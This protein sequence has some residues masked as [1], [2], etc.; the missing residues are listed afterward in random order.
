MNTT[1][2][3][4]Y[5]TDIKFRNAVKKALKGFT[6]LG[7]N[8]VSRRYTV[9]VQTATYKDDITYLITY[10]GG[11]R[12]GNEQPYLQKRSEMENQLAAAGFEMTT[13]TDSFGEPTI[14]WRKAVN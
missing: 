6:V 11:D 7:K 2:A 14:A 8:E 9:R 3:T 1:T 4:E 5:L 12:I 10:R 13:A